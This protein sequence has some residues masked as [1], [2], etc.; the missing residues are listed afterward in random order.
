MLK[1]YVLRRKILSGNFTKDPGNPWKT[2]GNSSVKFR[3]W[4]YNCEGVFRLMYHITSHFE[5]L[6]ILGTGEFLIDG[7]FLTFFCQS[8][9]LFGLLGY[10]GF[11][12]KIPKIY[13]SILDLDNFGI[14][15]N[16]KEFDNR[17]NYYAKGAFLYSQITILMN[18]IAPI[19]EY[20]N[21][22]KRENNYLKICGVRNTWA[23]FDITVF[24]YKQIIFLA[25]TY[26][27]IFS[28]SSILQY[29]R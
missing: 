18:T 13:K 9:I 17:M 23:P 10:S 14:P 27:G 2:Q 15:D 29:C 21:C 5:I 6:S 20:K 8:G 4:L 1:N 16:L 11:V 19:F 7:D 26:T 28:Y 22:I 25:S 3:I 12:H 24:P